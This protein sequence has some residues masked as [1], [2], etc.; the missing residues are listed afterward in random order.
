MS[1]R[2]DGP[3]VLKTEC[4]SLGAKK[5]GKVRD[6]YDLGEHLLLVAT[7]RISAFDVVLPQGIPGKGF[8]LTQMSVFWFDLIWNKEKIV[9]HHLIST[10]VSQF[11][12]ACQP[13][14][15]ILSGRSMLVKKAKPLPVECIVRGY[16]SGSGWKE[17]KK[18]GTVCGESLPHGLKESDRLPETIFTPSTKTTEGHDINISYEKMKGLVDPAVAEEVKEKSLQVYKKASAYSESRGIIIA[19]T[20]FEF[21]IDSAT[22]RLL[23]IDEVLTPDSSRFWPKNLYSPG[24]AQPSFDK[25]FVRDY[26]DSISWDR[27]PPPPDLPKEIIEKTSQKYFDALDQL[28]G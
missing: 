11:P 16:L 7:D 12:K 14:K 1:Q 6:I 27:N 9:H 21:G 26:L 8:V 5:A 28:T 22:Q 3:V 4:H 20:K 10:D 25:Q 19:D 13:Y 2:F 15:D 24:G 18:Q 23:I 17:Y